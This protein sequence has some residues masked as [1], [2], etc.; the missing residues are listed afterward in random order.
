MEKSGDQEDSKPICEIHSK[1]TIEKQQS[2]PVFGALDCDRSFNDHIASNG[3]SGACSSG[4]IHIPDKHASMKKSHSTSYNKI[5]GGN[6]LGR[7]KDR[8]GVPV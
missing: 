8:T 7:I 6:V 5:Q 1:V 2:S 3:I 4:N